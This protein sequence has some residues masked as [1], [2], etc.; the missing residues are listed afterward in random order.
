MTRCL[1]SILILTLLSALLGSTSANDLQTPKAAI[2]ASYFG[3]HIHNLAS[4][5][6]T[7]WPNL[8][9]P[10]WRLWDANVTWADLEPAKGQWRFEKLDAYVSLAEKHG[11]GLLL[12]L[13]GSPTWASANPQLKSNYY[14]GFTAEPSKIEDWR[15]YVRTVVSRYKGRIQAYEIW[16]EPNLR[17]SW[18]GSI[19]QMLTLTREASPI[20][21]NADPK[22]LVVSPSAT[23]SYGVPWLAEFLQKGGGQYVDVIAYHFYVDPN[24]APE[25]MLP[26]IQRVRKLLAEN[27]FA[28]KPVWNT[29]TGWL[30][31]AKFESDEIAAAFLA[32]A[33]I[34]SWAAGVQRLYWYAWDN[35]YVA[36][37]TYKIDTQT[38]TPAGRAYEVIQNWIGGTTMDD[39]MENADHTWT[40]TLNRNGKRQW[41][42]WNALGSRKFD[43]PPTWK[44]ATATRLLQDSVVLKGSTVDIGPVP[45][46]LT[47]R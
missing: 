11:T 9:V 37:K 13:G 40:C 5:V 4:P 7:P 28:D 14:P 6:P 39:C 31:P 47:Q 34:L 3:M 23:A 26:I 44:A 2:P 41:I 46:L 17:D 1:S 27:S 19:D 16:N 24:L 33:F 36:L 35:Q 15:D 29:E 10:Q 43:V 22:A 38:A 21:R 30:P 8:P 25:E 20:I 42:V 12:T 32:R 45:V 18:S